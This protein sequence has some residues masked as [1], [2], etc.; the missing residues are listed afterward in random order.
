M[1]LVT[2]LQS[3]FKAPSVP[4]YLKD[5]IETTRTAYAPARVAPSESAADRALRTEL[6][7]T[8]GSFSGDVDDSET[9]F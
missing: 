8:S 1:K 4:D 5:R 7:N 2:I 6:K 3:R 9:P